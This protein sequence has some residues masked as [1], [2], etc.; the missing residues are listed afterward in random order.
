MSSDF[1]KEQSL[2]AV[3]FEIEDC[4]NTIQ[5]AMT[6]LR[7]EISIPMPYRIAYAISKYSNGFIKF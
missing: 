3:D 5:N 7:I 6:Y 2:N 4:C 1:N